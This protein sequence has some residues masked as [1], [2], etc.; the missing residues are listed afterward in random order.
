MENRI[1]L[2]IS[3]D[4]D[5]AIRSA[6]DALNTNLTPLLIS[7]T[8]EQRKALSKMDNDSIPFVSDALAYAEKEPK[9]APPSVDVPELKIDFAAVT[10]LHD[11]ETLL[12]PIMSGIDD[13]KMLSGYE[14]YKASRSIYKTLKQAADENV[15]GAKD[16][17]EN[18]SKRFKGQGN[19]KKGSSDDTVNP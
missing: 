6:I 14:A 19:F 11:Y 10:T 17:Y 2:K 18:L 7:L 5:A 3:P 15:P 9:F 4:V 16:A 12:N 13:A 1:S 8:K